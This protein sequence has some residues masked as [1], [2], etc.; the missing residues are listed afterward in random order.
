MKNYYVL[1]IIGSLVL[2]GGCKKTNN[3]PDFHY[4]YFG[5]EEGRYIIY[6]VMDIVH[7]DQAAIKHDTSLY[8]LK[9]VWMGEYIDDQGRVGREFWRYTRDSSTDPWVLADVWTG[10][11]DGIHAELIEENQRKLKLVFSPTAQKLW[12]ANVYN[13]DQEYECYYRD[14]HG[15]TTINGTVFD[16]TC[17][18]EIYSQ[19]SL[20][21]SVHLFETYAKGIGLINK[22][23]KDIH[24]QFDT[25]SNVWFLDQGNE[26]YYTFVSAGFE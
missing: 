9:T 10:L 18:V 7:D 4:D 15:D 16:T 20:I 1:L 3:A 5:L 21:D 11:I 17:V 23:S 26:F 12:D 14:I 24:F 19:S 8:Q 22:F 2:L 13:P 25:V 6:D